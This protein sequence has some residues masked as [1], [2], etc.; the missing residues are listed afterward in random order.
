MIA[1]LVMDDVAPAPVSYDSTVARN[2]CSAQEETP[3]VS[4]Q[5]KSRAKGALKRL[6][7][8]QHYEFVGVEKAYA[9]AR[10]SEQL[11]SG[12]TY[13]SSGPSKPL[14]SAAAML[15]CSEFIATKPEA[16]QLTALATAISH[17]VATDFTVRAAENS[18]SRNVGAIWERLHRAASQQNQTYSDPF[19]E[20]TVSLAAT[21][22]AADQLFLLHE[23]LDDRISLNAAL[24]ASQWLLLHQ[25]A[26]GGYA[27]DRVEAATG[28]VLPDDRAGRKAAV[29]AA[30][31]FIRAYQASRIEVYVLAA[32]RALRSAI[33]RLC[34]ESMGDE[35]IDRIARVAAM[36]Y[37]E[38]ASLRNQKELEQAAEWLRLQQSRHSI[39]CCRDTSGETSDE[40]T[41][42]ALAALDIFVALNQPH[43]LDQA[44]QSLGQASA[45]RSCAG[46]SS[47]EA[48][49]S[50]LLALPALVVG[51]QPDLRDGHVRVGWTSYSA[52]T[53]VNEIISVRSVD[54][55]SADTIDSLPLVSKIGH[56]VLVP[57][58]AEKH[59]ARVSITSG[60]R[61]PCLTDLVTGETIHQPASLHD[62]PFECNYKWGCF[63]IEN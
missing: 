52:D 12:G 34:L 17:G 50:T 39:L 61:T 36:L 46:A 28:R 5:L 53:A 31:A 13:L 30:G 10:E 18:Q 42:T 56:S 43:W 60:Q 11:G 9:R 23:R 2:I 63:L 35:P 16:V 22:D 26:D 41:D 29:Y 7:D 37:A 38:S 51:C 21:A 8:P 24:R 58:L 59:V 32:L 20:D 54:S 40:H 62:L 6:A 1:R 19:G 4:L 44:L 33:S 57:I 45:S 55:E 48:Y 25:R 49:F 27:G 3:P 47:I 15:R 14:D